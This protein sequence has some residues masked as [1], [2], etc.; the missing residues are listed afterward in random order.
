M[1]IPL[2]RSRRTIREVSRNRTRDIIKGTW[3]GVL[4]GDL[5]RNLHLWKIDAQG[6]RNLGFGCNYLAFS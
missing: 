4:T 3:A 1:E 6:G 5:L 2:Q